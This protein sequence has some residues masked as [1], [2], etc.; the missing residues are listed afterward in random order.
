MK[1][2]KMILLLLAAFMLLCLAA[3][4][5]SE[6]GPDPNSPD[7]ASGTQTVV[8]QGFDWGP[9]VTKTIITLN[10]TVTADSVKA[11][12]F[13]VVEYK[14]NLTGLPFGLHFTGDEDRTVTAAYP[15]NA[16]GDP[17]E[18]ASNMIALELA[19][20][21]SEGSP[22]CYG[23]MT[24][25]NT[26][27]DPYELKISLAE[28]CALT[29]TDG[30]SITGLAVSKEIDLSAAYIPQLEN[31][32]LSGE[33]TG[34]DGRTLTY[35]SFA[36]AE[37]GQKHPLVIWL[38][39]AGEG[40]TDPLVAL[41]GNEVSVLF[42]E[43]FQSVMGGAYVLVP[44]TP[45]FWMVYNEKGDWQ[46]NPGTDSVYLATLMELIQDHVEENADIDPD[47]IYI[48]GCSNGGYMTMDLI[49]QNPDYF[50][51][52]FPIC[53]S[54]QD[55]GI[56]DEQ[57][58]GI[59]D[60]PVWF[61]YAEND[62]TVDPEKHEIPTIERLRALGADVHTSVFE[63]VHDTSG[64]WFEE[65]GTPHQYNGHWSWIYFFNNE[66]EENGVS[67]WQWLAQQNKSE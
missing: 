32:D 7:V 56:T 60:L 17:V 20:G 54:Y 12:N 67:L 26:V 19:Y 33:F 21:P 42:G 36:P 46:D 57:L 61:V 51:A 44:Q 23:L 22:F 52:A 43:E 11:E 53:E 47:R 35:A 34:E 15:C 28:G 62:G 39:G 63:D 10:R 5:A 65:D 2:K 9:A 40:G 27:C 55:A 1:Y 24:S 30:G 45:E 38:H 37:D 13:A 59:K 66:C 58:A 3:C 6:E 4:G 41:L 31:V 29:D 48:G 49:L 25:K 64:N 18:G 8:I 14:E 50:A 16:A